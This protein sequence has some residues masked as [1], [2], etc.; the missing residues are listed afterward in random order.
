MSQMNGL[1]GNVPNPKWAPIFSDFLYLTASNIEAK[2]SH[3]TAIKS[4]GAIS[5]L[6]FSTYEGEFLL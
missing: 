2:D 3:G 1:L 6:N 4:S 5:R